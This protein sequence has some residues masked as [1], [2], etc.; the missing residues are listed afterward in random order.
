M[1]APTALAPRGL[2]TPTSIDY[3]AMWTDNETTSDYLG[4]RV[5]AD[6]IHAV[7][8]DK[9]LLPV[10][11]GVFGDWGGG[12]TS[13]LRML[14]QD[15]EPER[16][17]DPEV[18]AKH[19][20]IAC[21]YV[22]GWL[23]E[24][25]DDAKAAL[26]T[27]IL[28]SLGEH[29][30]FGPKL[31]DKA[32]SLLKSVNWM[33]VA[34][35]GIKDVALPAVAAYVTGGATAI[36]AVASMLAERTGL[37]PEKKD[38]SAAAAEKDGDEVDWESLIK[39]DDGAAG[40]LDVR[41]FRDRFAKMLSDSSIDT[42]V[43]LIDDLD[44]CA[45][46]QIVDNLEAIKLFLNVPGTAFVIGADPR[47]VRHAIAR[48]YETQLRGTPEDRETDERLVNDYLEKVIQIPYSLPR[49][50]PA[51]TETYMALLFAGNYLGADA[52]QLCMKACDTQRSANHYGVFGYAS[53]KAAVGSQK[54]PEELTASLLFSAGAAPL[55]TEG[56][57]GNPRQVKRFLNALM[58]R[59]R[60]A[61]IAKLAHLKDE[62]LVKLMILEYAHPKLFQDLFGW[63]V[64]QAGFPSELSKMEGAWR[65]AQK[66][67]KSQAGGEL[68]WANE[69]AKRWI[70]MDPALSEVDLRDYFWIAR[71]RLAS[72]LSGVSLIPPGVRRV[73]EDLL[74]DNAGKVKAAAVAAVSFD[75]DHRQLLLDALA[76][77][78]IR[79]PQ[80]KAAYD[81]VRHLI[82]NGILDAIRALAD[83]A[84]KLPVDRIPPSV[85]LD[86]RT[87]AATHTSIADK[88]QPMLESWA[89]SD[90]KVGRALTAR[91][92]GR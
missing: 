29:K 32:A 35:F 85:G 62:V 70:Q 83:A 11:V 24:G 91:S 43:V 33:R 68:P 19:E 12:K 13:V 6:L 14:Q 74:S 76:E 50:S 4:F 78:L 49:L 54:L 77:N 87:L 10:T 58:L 22:N 20:K 25:Y 46:D 79:H 5:H 65:G 28:L 61:T 15:L 36:P 23:F 92:K 17:T 31:R 64:A 60:L 8:T 81:A 69:F 63:Q 44:R 47:I 18:K 72:T 1:L 7:V 27:A 34:R 51:E 59:K 53:V 71:D 66:V 16:Q 39:K 48:R 26:L 42:L 9:A 67:G 73:L 55:I 80:E 75:A 38:P 88:I 3:P 56:L 37:I 86:Y 52:F 57:K 40:P 2:S 45:P 41:T 21:L 89:E 82:D 90:T 84:S 30:R